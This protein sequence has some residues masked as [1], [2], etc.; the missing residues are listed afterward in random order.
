MGKG[1]QGR[2]LVKMALTIA[3]VLAG[4]PWAVIGCAL[5]STA[6]AALVS[7]RN[8]AGH[9]LE[10]LLIGLA[11]TVSGGGSVIA[12][13]YILIVTRGFERWNGELSDRDRVIGIITMLSVLW[14]SGLWYYFSGLLLEILA[15]CRRGL[16]F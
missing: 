13:I 12:G 15:V 4:L 6:V 1:L 10:F 5:L 9:G 14:N 16:S 3:S 11:M 2:R 8:T 7:H